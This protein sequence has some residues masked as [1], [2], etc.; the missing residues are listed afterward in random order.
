M[1]KF[2]KKKISGRSCLSPPR[3]E[4]GG[5]KDW[6]VS[7]IILYW[8][9]KVD[10]FAGWTLPKLPIISKNCSNKSIWA[11]HFKQKSQWAHMSISPT[12]GATGLERLVCFKDYIVLKWKVHSFAGWTP[13][14]LLIISKNASN[15]NCL[16]L[17]FIQKS[18]Q[19]HMSISSTSGAGKRAPKISTFEIL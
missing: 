18:P 3:V 6:Y 15:K 5:L 7:K 19:A 9:G 17:N 13:L 11:L 12:S 8:K 1:I 14:K 10:S 16:K 2:R 4:L